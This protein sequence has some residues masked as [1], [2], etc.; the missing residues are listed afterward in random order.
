[1]LR[2]KGFAIIRKNGRWLC[3]VLH[4]DAQNIFELMTQIDRIEKIQPIDNES[5]I[6]YLC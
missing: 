6:G 5:A 2:Y 1:M 4:I 3:E